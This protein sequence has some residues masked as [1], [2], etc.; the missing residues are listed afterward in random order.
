MQCVNNNTT[1]ALV[2]NSSLNLTRERERERERDRKEK[3]ERP[4]SP[5]KK[6]KW[7]A[8]SWTF[9]VKIF[10]SLRSQLAR[11]LGTSKSLL[12]EARVHLFLFPAVRFL[13]DRA[14]AAHRRNFA[15]LLSL[16]WRQVSAAESDYGLVFLKAPFSGQ[17]ETRRK[18]LILCR[19]LH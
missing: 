7:F 19:A 6:L 16:R 8:E 14:G 4:M 10:E 17:R 13:D 9:S 11:N 18:P 3:R 5:K 2:V 12:G 15:A 1:L